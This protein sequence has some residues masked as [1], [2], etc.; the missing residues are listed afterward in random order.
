MKKIHCRLC[1]I[2]FL[3]VSIAINSNKLAPIFTNKSTL[4]HLLNGRGLML[5]LIPNIQN[6]LK[7][8][9]PTTFHIA[10]SDCF[11]YAAIAEVANSGSDVPIATTVRPITAWL[12]HNTVAICTAPSTIQVPPKVSHHNHKIM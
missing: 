11:L 5:E 10:I 7:M 12:R 9:D 4:L 6:V 1:R 2:Y 3:P 8:F